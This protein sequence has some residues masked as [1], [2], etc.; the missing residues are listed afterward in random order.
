MNARINART[1]FLKDGRP[2]YTYNYLQREITTI[3][4]PNP[5][6]PG[7]ATVQV[8]FRYDGGGL[9]KGATVSLNVNG[10]KVA[11]GR[12]ART[13]AVTYSYDETF[14]IGQDTSTAVGDYQA[15]FPFT[16][17]LHKVELENNPPRLAP[18]EPS[19]PRDRSRGN[20]H[21]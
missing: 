16:G 7:P 13:V 19:G 15:P 11:E 10:K 14:D 2:S 17:T 8:Q 6:P 1:I 4:D 21:A 5:L 12:L 18:T 3:A 9:G 20:L